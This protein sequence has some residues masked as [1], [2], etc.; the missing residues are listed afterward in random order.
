[1]PTQN[2]NVFMFQ[3]VIAMAYCRYIYMYVV[4]LYKDVAAVKENKSFHNS[5]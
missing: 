2:G 5:T 3:Y 1:L 4:Y